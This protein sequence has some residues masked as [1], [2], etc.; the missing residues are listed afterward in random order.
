MYYFLCTLRCTI[1]KAN[2]L[3]VL[4]E[5]I[6]CMYN[7]TVDRIG[8]KHLYSSISTTVSFAKGNV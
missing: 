6:S 3:C 2:C 5:V 7:I 1:V 8:L 4:P